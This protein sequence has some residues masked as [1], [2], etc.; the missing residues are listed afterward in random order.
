MVLASGGREM[1]L[2][3]ALALSKHVYRKGRSVPLRYELSWPMSLEDAIA[4]DWEVHPC[5]RSDLFGKARKVY[6]SIQG[7]GEIQGSAMIQRAFEE[8]SE[9]E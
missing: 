7:L 3:D 2:T 8:W 4:D 9:E 5:D 1:T 6:W